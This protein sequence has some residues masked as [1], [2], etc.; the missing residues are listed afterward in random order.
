MPFAHAQ[1]WRASWM[2][3]L[4]CFTSLDAWNLRDLPDLSNGQVS[5][6]AFEIVPANVHTN[7]L[8]VV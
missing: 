8:F 5:M 1:T 6:A 7:E 2:L 3:T 4:P